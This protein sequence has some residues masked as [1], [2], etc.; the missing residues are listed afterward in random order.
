MA[1]R[2]YPSPT[3]D[4]FR[5]QL[6]ALE[7]SLVSSLHA[8]FEMVRKL[9]RKEEKSCAAAT[10]AAA[11]SAETQHVYLDDVSCLERAEGTG[12]KFLKKVREDL[13]PFFSR[14][15]EIDLGFL[16]EQ[17]IGEAV[18]A[19]RA[20]DAETL[21][22]A[23][24]EFLKGATDGE[25]FRLLLKVGAD[26][27]GLVEGQTALIRAIVA[28]NMAA[29]EM[30]VD[31]GA[32]L[33]GKVGELPEGFV[34][35]GLVPGD[36]PLIVACRLRQWVIVKYLIA[37]GADVEVC[38]GGGLKVLAI[39]CEAVE[40]ELDTAGE[41]PQGGGWTLQYNPQTVDPEVR[42]TVGEC[43]KELVKKTS[44]IASMKIRP[45]LR[46]AEDT[47]VHF[48]AWHGFEDL[49]LLSLSR[50]VD[51]DSLDASGFTAFHTSAVR[52]QPALVKL[53]IA[54]GADISKRNHYTNYSVLM[55]M[56]SVSAM[57]PFTKGADF[58][59]SVLKVLEI[60]VGHGADV[61]ARA[62]GR[63]VLF[64]AVRWGVPEVVKFLIDR[65]ADLQAQNTLGET[66]HAVAV[67][68]KSPPEI[69]EL[70]RP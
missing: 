36:T 34:D 6:D 21:R 22:K 56:M 27:N 43:L 46:Y 1:Q 38:D 9:L 47:L 40:R 63:T 41:D 12:K 8:Q 70:L 24:S 57:Y 39:A 33:E 50:G 20:V 25:S 13:H 60:L 18:H 15:F 29:V 64:E 51:I 44:D 11:A 45:P 32:D 28:A 59:S 23:Q 5:G 61:N 69:F 10:A 19:L 54:N 37:K 66:P 48:F 3:I 62:E 49:V 16:L 4:F 26:V 14:R 42:S 58:M 53:L 35:V 30:L 68:F 67:K 2:S 52:G 55:I 31:D 65:G 17:G 7:A